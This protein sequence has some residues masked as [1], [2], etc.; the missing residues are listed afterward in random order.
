MTRCQMSWSDG[1][2]LDA[3]HKT[4]GVLLLRVK[5]FRRF[6]TVGGPP[7]GLVVSVACFGG[8]PQAEVL[9]RG[10]GWVKGG[11]KRG[12]GKVQPLV[13]GGGCGGVPAGAGS[14]QRGRRVVSRGSAGAGLRVGAE[15][16][17]AAVCVTAGGGSNGRGA[18]QT[19]WILD[20]EQD[21]LA[22]IQ[23]FATPPAV[24]DGPPP[25]ENPTGFGEEWAAQLGSVTQAARGGSCGF[26]ES[27]RCQAGHPESNPLR[28]FRALCGD[29]R[30]MDASYPSGLERGVKGT[31]RVRGGRGKDV[32]LGGNHQSG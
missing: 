18:E 6:C 27:Q 14:G 22:K 1:R 11:R 12:V 9:Y 32:L 30:R 10:S 19:L 2:H 21:A 4:S 16:S 3:R 31:G 23:G 15:G 13:H 20:I 5:G 29:F 28:A 25:H 8:R 7:S 26:G 24:A 17:T